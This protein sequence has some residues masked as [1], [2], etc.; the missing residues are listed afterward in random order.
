MLKNNALAAYEYCILNKYSGWYVIFDVTSLGAIDGSNVFKKHQANLISAVAPKA[1]VDCR[2]YAAGVRCCVA[3][4]SK[5][6]RLSDGAVKVGR[7]A[8]KKA[9]ARSRSPAAGCRKHI[10]PV[11][12]PGTGGACICAA[13]QYLYIPPSKYC[14]Y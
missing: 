4:I 13:A 5:D 8:G 6:A 12:Q 10:L 2:T 9:V 14:Y 11:C 3:A 1:V 7:T